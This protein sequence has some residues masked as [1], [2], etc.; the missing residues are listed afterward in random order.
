MLATTF[1]AVLILGIFAWDIGLR[2]WRET[3][4]RRRWRRK[5]EDDR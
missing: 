1:V 4:W 3:A 2:W 5:D